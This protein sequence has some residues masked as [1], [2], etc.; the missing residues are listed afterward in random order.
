MKFLRPLYLALARDPQTRTVAERA[1][2]RLSAGYHPIAQQMVQG[3]LR[4]AT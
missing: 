4:A 3:V 2:D 1:F